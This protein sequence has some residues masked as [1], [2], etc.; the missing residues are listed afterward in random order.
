MN[1]GG[2]LFFGEAGGRVA[3]G[4]EGSKHRLGLRGF[5]RPHPGP[6]LGGEPLFQMSEAFP[7]QEALGDPEGG[8]PC[9]S[10]ACRGGTS[11]IRVLEDATGRL[12]GG[13]PGRVG[14]S[15]GADPLNIRG[16]RDLSRASL[17]LRQHRQGQEVDASS[18][19]FGGE[20]GY[21]RAEGHEL[22]AQIQGGAAR[23]ERPPPG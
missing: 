23:F 22:R 12:E 6:H 2:G 1:H 15:E 10:P 20:T 9:R 18:H 4:R 11:E 16:E 17:E 5:P 13:R 21:L 3:L 19:V 8:S 7:R 14:R